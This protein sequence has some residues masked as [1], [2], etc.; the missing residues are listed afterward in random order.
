VFAIFLNNFNHP[1]IHFDANLLY[2]CIVNLLYFAET[3][4]EF[5]E[6][7]FSAAETKQDLVDRNKNSIYE[8]STSVYKPQSTFLTEL[9]SLHNHKTKEL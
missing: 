5:S 6:T 7:Y 3:K 8:K 4:Q 2:R 1:I 9:S